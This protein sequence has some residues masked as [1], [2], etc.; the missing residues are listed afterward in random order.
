MIIAIPFFPGLTDY[1]KAA[2]TLLKQGDCPGHR[3]LVVTQ[4]P[5]EEE[6]ITFREELAPLFDKSVVKVIETPAEGGLVGLS[7]EM[8]RAA[9]RD[10]PEPKSGDWTGE[11]NPNMPLLY[12]DPTWRPAKTG[13]LDS[14]QSEYF[15]NG[16]PSFTGCWT[17]NKAGEKVPYGPV[18]IAPG[19]AEG[20]GLLAHL[21]AHQHWRNYLRYE[22]GTKLIASRTIGAVKGAVLRPPL[23]KK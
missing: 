11:I 8:F 13:W 9:V 16:A 17:K 5:D 4:R 14:L 10:L 6:A 22:I 23:E 21:P 12:F 7:N 19:Y 2:A 1:D 20:S 3:L 18:L 15:S